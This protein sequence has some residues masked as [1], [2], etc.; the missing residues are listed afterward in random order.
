[1]WHAQPQGSTSVTVVLHRETVTRV[2]GGGLTNVVFEESGISRK[3]DWKARPG[4][5]K[6]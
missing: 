2:I 4:A 1:M 6:S 5:R 3:A